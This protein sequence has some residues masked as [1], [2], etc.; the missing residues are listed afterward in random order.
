MINVFCCWRVV[1][2]VFFFAASWLW[3][4][5]GQ[6]KDGCNLHQRR[7]EHQLGIRGNKEQ[8]TDLLFTYFIIITITFILIFL[9]TQIIYHQI[10]KII[11]TNL[12]MIKF[13]STFNYE[14]L[15]TE[16]TL[17][18]LSKSQNWAAGPWPDQTSCQWNRLNFQEVLLKVT[19]SF[20]HNV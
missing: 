4:A 15:N 11:Y 13:I 17:R 3:Y 6:P 18:A 5:A 16:W 10:I 7:N 1:V 8:L 2:V 14:N 9:F 19:I 20:V 12:I